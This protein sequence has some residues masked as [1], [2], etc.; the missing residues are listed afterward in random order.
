VESTIA[1]LK[2]Y[3]SADA[4][5]LAKER[6]IAGSRQLDSATAQ[7]RPSS[8]GVFRVAAFEFG[9]RNDA[10]VK[11]CLCPLLA[12]PHRSAYDRFLALLA[13]PKGRS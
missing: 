4:R 7:S 12:L 10:K 11:Q 2:P 6:S 9:H 1:L 5:R 8:L 13:R 3:R